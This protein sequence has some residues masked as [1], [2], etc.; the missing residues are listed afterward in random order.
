MHDAVVEHTPVQKAVARIQAAKMFG[1]TPAEVTDEL[2]AAHLD[3]APSPLPPALPERGIG[4]VALQR[5]PAP[6]PLAVSGAVDPLLLGDPDP[7]TDVS[8]FR[9]AGA[10]GA[11]A[12]AAFQRHFDSNPGAYAHMVF[13]NA[14]RAR[15]SMAESRPLSEES[16][17]EYVADYFRGNSRPHAGHMAFG[18]ALATDQ[19]AA[20]QNTQALDTLCRLLVAM[21]QAQLDHDAWDLAWLLSYLPQPPWGR[22]RAASS[23]ADQR[24]QFATLAEPSMV[25]TAIAHVRDLA[26]VNEA[27]TKMR[28]WQPKGPGKGKRG[29][30]WPVPPEDK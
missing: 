6:P 15:S 13:E 21:E 3:T 8:L 29:K 17:R 24:T 23:A 2:L 12:Q 22:Y 25:S 28:E 20:N 5:R 14:R 27:R 18:I 30:D 26:A 1:L 10:R 16:M 19:L 7:Q 11:A 4:A 9:M